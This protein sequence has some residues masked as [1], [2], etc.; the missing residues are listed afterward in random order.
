MHERIS[1]SKSC[2]E[3]RECSTQLHSGIVVSRVISRARNHQ[4]HLASFF[5]L[6]VFR[7]GKG[8]QRSRDSPSAVRWSH[9]H[10]SR[11]S[12]VNAFYNTRKIDCIL[13]ASTRY[14]CK[15]SSISPHGRRDLQIGPRFSFRLS[16]SARWLLCSHTSS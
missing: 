8:S 1:R 9:H 5:K 6:Q 3:C 11:S 7:M 4:Q 2:G 15:A 10:L 13:L 12:S 16:L 14:L